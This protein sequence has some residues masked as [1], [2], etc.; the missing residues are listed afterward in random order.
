[1]AFAVDATGERA[2]DKVQ[3]TSFPVPT[4]KYPVY[5]ISQLQEKIV[6]GILVNARHHCDAPIYMGMDYFQL[7]PKIKPL[8]GQLWRVPSSH[9][10]WKKSPT[11]RVNGRGNIFYHARPAGVGIMV[12]DAQKV[13]TETATIKCVLEEPVNRRVEVEG[14][15]LVSG[16]R[17]AMHQCEGGCANFISLKCGDKVKVEMVQLPDGCYVGASYVL[18]DVQDCDGKPLFNM[19]ELRKS[20]GIIQPK[21]GDFFPTYI[22][23]HKKKQ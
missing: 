8:V 5:F 7:D 14:K 23:V 21:P 12:Q 2:E 11:L 17:L 16:V 10:T 19:R 13:R 4:S 1:M 22:R 3:R 9:W 6:L 18:P 20:N 15:R